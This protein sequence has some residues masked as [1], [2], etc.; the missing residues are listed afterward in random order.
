[1]RHALFF[2]ILFSF[3]FVSPLAQAAPKTLN[4]RMVDIP[5]SFDWTG[6]VTMAEAPIITNIC[7]GLYGYQYPKETLIPQIAASLKKSKDFTE[8]TFTLRPDAKWS[9][10]RPI[11][12]QDFVDGWMRLLSPQSPSI[13][14]YYL[15]DVYKAKEYNQGKTTNRDEIGIKALD[16]HTLW[17]KLKR[18]MQ[19][20][21]IN[22]AFWPLF[23][24]RKDQ[25]EKYGA[26]WWRAGIL[27]S[28]GPYVVDSYEPGSKVTLKRNAFYGKTKSN[29]DQVVIQILQSHEAAFNLYQNKKLDLM[30]D[31]PFE[32][33][34]TLSKRPDF[35]LID[36]LRVHY[37]GINTDKFP[38]N[39]KIFRRAILSAIDKYN[40]GPTGA[41]NLKPAGTMIEPPLVGSAKNAFVPYNPVEAKK[42]LL[43]SGM[44]VNSSLKLNLLTTLSEPFATIGKKIQEQLSKTLGL[45]VELSALQNQEYNAYMNLGDY[46][47]FINSWTAK[48]AAP[49]D[50]LLPLAGSHNR[51]HFVNSFFDQYIFEGMEALTSTH[52]EEAF[53]K[54]QKLI[55]DEEAVITPLF[56][57]K[58]GALVQPSI[59]N[60]YFNKQ[61]LMVLKDVVVP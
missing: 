34:A 29:V 49:Q 30:A 55:A 52:A 20:W 7:E 3:I 5:V 40:V 33:M 11:Y 56:F 44:V 31:L 14:I 60:L 9:D 41:I 54:A 35:H 26:N 6:Q 8:Y 19:N 4:A 57:E 28:S 16:D 18:P 15:Y 10:G 36:L 23:P 46:N 39:N 43:Q 42:L 59:K 37:F 12:A 45:T 48:V 1:M 13:Y 27:V 25:I 22:T 50:F 38:M 47:G 53:Y 51:A 17:V 58:S 24:V 32:Q 2:Q 21:E 61:G